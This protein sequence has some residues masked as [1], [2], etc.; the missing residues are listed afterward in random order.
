MPSTLTPSAAER[1]ELGAIREHM[2]I[3]GQPVRSGQGESIAVHDPAT[4]EIIARVP[5]AG[6]AEIDQAVRSARRA[7]ESGSWR[8]MLPAGRE[9]LLLALADLVERHGAELAR[10]ETLN[11]GKL[12]GVA[13]GLEVGS[14]AQWLRYM[15][16]W[17]TKITG[18]TLSLSIP[19]PP[20]TQYSAYTLP[21]AVGVVG[22]IIP[23]NFPLLM[24]IW[25]IAPA[26][27]AG[28]TVVLKPAE[29][30]PLTALRLGE[31]VLEAGFPPGVVNV[32]TGRGETAGAALVAHPGVD[33]IAFTGS[34]E[35]GKLIGRAAVDDMKR[36]SLELG[37]KSPVIVLDDCDVDRAV[38]ARRPRSSST[39]AR[40]APP[41]RACT[42]SAACTRR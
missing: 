39:R 15:A 38:Q 7:F 19:F 30:T 11:N 27:A 24:A 20:G 42:C 3:D 21:Q 31:L 12:L 35:V 8:D 23:W 41:A 34:T 26:L 18:E 40:S 16:G 4:G 25:K 33:K 9:R 10:L 17:A 5:D 37:G 36:V 13:Q 2:L 29:E 1:P 14:G 6:A 28:C 32:V 22:A